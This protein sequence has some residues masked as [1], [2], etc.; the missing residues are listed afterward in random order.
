MDS[1]S[2]GPFDAIVAA[3]QVALAAAPTT[4]EYSRRKRV[5]QAYVD[6]LDPTKHEHVIRDA[7]KRFNDENPAQD[8]VAAVRQTLKSIGRVLK[9]HGLQ[10]T[11]ET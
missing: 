5:T 10:T 11:A 1:E 8:S 3:Y 2:T 4:S 7:W 9:N 6:S